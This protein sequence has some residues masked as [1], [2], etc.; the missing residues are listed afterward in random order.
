VFKKLYFGLSELLEKV[1]TNDNPYFNAFIGISFF[2]C[3]NVLTISAIIN[4]FFTFNVSK[5]IAIYLGIII[6]VIITIFNFFYLFRKRN[7]IEKKFEEYSIEKRRKGK[8]YL[9]TYI[10]LTIVI[11]LFVIIY[12][13]TPKY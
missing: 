2:Q 13:T 3:M 1:R 4:Y 8:L 5:N 10:L 9:W 12:M 7:E 6:Y 11:F